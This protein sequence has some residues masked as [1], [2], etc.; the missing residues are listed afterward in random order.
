MLITFHNFWQNRKVWKK[1]PKDHHRLVT[2]QVLIT[3]V[4]WVRYVKQYEIYY[5]RPNTPKMWYRSPLC[6]KSRSTLGVD[7]E[8]K[9]SPPS[10]KGVCIDYWSWDDFL[11]PP[12]RRLETMRHTSWDETL[13]IRELETPEG[14]VIGVPGSI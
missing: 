7:N 6:L 9:E 8:E 12:W 13:E 4:W 3:T 5:D 10:T 2:N 14:R 11:T 1:T